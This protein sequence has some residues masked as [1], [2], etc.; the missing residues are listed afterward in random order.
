MEELEPGAGAAAPEELDPVDPPD[1]LDPVDE[2]EPL[3]PVEVPVA[4]PALPEP[5]AAAAVAFLSIPPWPLHA[6]RPPWGEV[7]PS[8]QVTGLLV[9]AGLS[10]G[11]VNSA[12]PANTPQSN[13]AYLRMTI[14]FSRCCS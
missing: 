7:V 5:A 13:D 6:P 8:L 9:S 1:E 12:A 10:A 3:D 4:V 2:L 14:S 11:S